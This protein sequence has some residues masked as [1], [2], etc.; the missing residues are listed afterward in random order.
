M[1]VHSVLGCLGGGL[2]SEAS[3]RFSSGTFVSLRSAQPHTDGFLD[4]QCLLHLFSL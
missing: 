2:C 4:R 3:V 1:E